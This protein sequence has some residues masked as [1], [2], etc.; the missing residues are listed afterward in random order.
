MEEKK[1]LKKFVREK[2]I[3]LPM[4]LQPRDIEILKS[5]ARHRFLNT[6]HIIAL[7][8][9]GPRNIL[10]RLQKLFKNGYIER[11]RQQA[12][13]TGP[14]GYMVH[15]IGNKGVALLSEHFSHFQRTKVDWLTKNKQ[16][17][18]RY[19]HHALMISNFWVVL[20][21]ALK[22]NHQ[23]NL[24]S[25]RQGRDLKDY[26][27][28]NGQRVAVVPDAFFTLEDSQSKMHFFLEADQ[29]TMTRG[30]FLKKMKAYWQWWKEGGQEKKFGIKAFRVLTICKSEQR[31]ENLRKVAKGAD[32]YR[33]GSLMFWFGLEK[34]F[35]L[36]ESQSILKP[37]WQTPV[38]NQL[39]SLL[40]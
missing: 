9:G 1:R 21:I 8:G 22:N 33:K 23:A 25:W 11:P 17:R 15:A 29:S 24:A 12:S 19:I 3:I 6:Q 7:Y 18:E 38:D 5:L 28:L 13:L 4:D 36:S 40:E 32:D 39:H 37:I 14:Q 20:T 35:D 26:V 27:K 31:R 2:G 34:E 16:V 10:R 30:R